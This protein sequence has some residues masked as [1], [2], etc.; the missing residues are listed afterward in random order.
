MCC[1]V[2]H[3]VLFNF[4]STY[5][6]PTDLTPCL[7]SFICTFQVYGDLLKSMKCQWCVDCLQSQ[8]MVAFPLMVLGTVLLPAISILTAVIELKGV[9]S[10]LLSF[11]TLSSQQSRSLSEFFGK[12]GPFNS[13]VLAR[14]NGSKLFIYWYSSP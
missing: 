9:F 3:F 6:N 12:K 10:P 1:N 14:N 5:L 2:Q 4:L 8:C 11:L 7:I 13:L